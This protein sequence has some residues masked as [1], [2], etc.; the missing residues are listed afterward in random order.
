MKTFRGF[1][2]VFLLPL[3]LL[4]GACDRGEDVL[5]PF[6]GA[7]RADLAGKLHGVAFGAVL[8]A[9]TPDG[10]GA[11]VLT[12]TFYA[13]EA[14]SGTVVTQEKDGTLSMAT[15][16][17]AVKGVHAKGFLPLL[18]ILPTEG[19]IERI[20]TDG[21]GHS[22]VTGKDFTLTLTRDGTPIAAG[23]AEVSATIIRFDLLPTP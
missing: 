2:L 10:E 22:V 17:V 18:A 11:R 12:L 9:D 4:L 1:F 21:E 14:L 5:T 19:E 16:G 6:R 13:P 7:Y 8:E 23:N 15:G 3:L 20:E